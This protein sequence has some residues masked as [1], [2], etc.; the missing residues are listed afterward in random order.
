MTNHCKLEESPLALGYRITQ[1]LIIYALAM[2]VKDDTG[3]F[4]LPKP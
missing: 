3:S 2:N 4:K 1:M